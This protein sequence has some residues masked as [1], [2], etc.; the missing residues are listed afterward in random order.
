MSPL[1]CVLIW[2]G[3]VFLFTMTFTTLFSLCSEQWFYSKISAHTE[4]IQENTWDNIYMS[5]LFG[6]SALVDIFLIFVIAKF[7]AYRKQ[8]AR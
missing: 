2:L 8:A 3:S 7:F 6:G 4:F 1:K 5:I